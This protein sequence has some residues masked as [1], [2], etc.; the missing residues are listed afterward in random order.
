MKTIITLLLFLLPSSRLL[1]QNVQWSIPLGTYQH[2]QHFTPNTLIVKQSGKYGLADV[3][4]KE[5]M[6]ACCDSITRLHNGWAMMLDCYSGS[7]FKLIGLLN[8]S[9]QHFMFPETYYTIPGME[10]VSEDYVAVVNTNGQKGYVSVTGQKLGF[11]KGYKNIMPFVEGYAGVMTQDGFSYVSKMLVPLHIQLPGVA[12]VAKGTSFHKGK[13]Y[14]WDTK[15][16]AYLVTS[17][18]TRRAKEMDNF[19]SGAK[20]DYLGRLQAVT[21]MSSDI[22]YDN[23]VESAGQSTSLLNQFIHS[24]GFMDGYAVVCNNKGQWG[25]LKQING[26]NQWEVTLDKEKYSYR[27]GGSVNCNVLLKSVPQ[28]WD[29]KDMTVT[30]RNVDDNNIIESRKVSD[31]KY[32][33]S[34]IPDDDS[35]EFCIDVS[36]SDMILYSKTLEAQFVRK[37]VQPLTTSVAIASRADNQFRAKVTVTIHN[38]NDEAYNGAISIEGSRNLASVTR[39]AVHIAPGGSTTITTYFTNIPPDGLSASVTV[40]DENGKTL[41][42]RSSMISL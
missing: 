3:T 15:H 17:S 36:S 24:T 27:K 21:K 29:G 5:L 6:P 35:Q 26:E 23:D 37:V 18:G 30:V 28:S 33:F 13:A 42:K 19:F 39:K 22:P 20:Y 38:N 40:K 12:V 4:G 2:I 32:S 14:V 11:N 8:R 31:S 10:Y 25:V 16:S 41:A 7:S 9:G 34:Y 1:A